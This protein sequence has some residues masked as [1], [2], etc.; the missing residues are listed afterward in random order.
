MCV[1]I[2]FLCLYLVQ[3]G[4]Q[5]HVASMSADQDFGTMNVHKIIV[6]SQKSEKII[7]MT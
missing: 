6:L 7:Y 5:W 4:A 3:S 2:N 1:Y